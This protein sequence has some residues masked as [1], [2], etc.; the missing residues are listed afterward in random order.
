MSETTAIIILIFRALG[1][2]ARSGARLIKASSPAEA[3][4]QAAIMA[5]FDTF[6]RVIV[7]EETVYTA[8][9]TD[10]APETPRPRAFG[11][12]PRA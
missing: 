2:N 12:S 5:T 9:D 7:R 8:E 1:P 11:R 3:H 6:A 4:R 10:D